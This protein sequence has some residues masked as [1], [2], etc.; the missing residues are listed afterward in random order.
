[1]LVSTNKYTRLQ[2]KVTITRDSNDM[3]RIRVRD[4]ASRVEFA[5]AEMTV[6]AFGYAITGLSDQPA[7]VTVAGL[8]FVGK[9]KVVEQRMA[10]CPLSTYDKAELQAWLVAN[11]AEAGWML[12]TYLG[13]QG[14]ITPQVGVTLLRYSVYKYVEDDNA[15]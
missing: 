9:R 6:E 4:D 2:G 1:M 10:R 13:S 5:T 7:E 12:N 11:A 14:S 3:I 15:S 8:E